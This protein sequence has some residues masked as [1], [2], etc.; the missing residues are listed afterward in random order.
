[1]TNTEFVKSQLQIVIDSSAQVARQNLSDWAR[2]F[3][4]E[5]P[6]D[7]F[8][9]WNAPMPIRSGWRYYVRAPHQLGTRES[10]GPGWYMDAGVR[11][12]PEEADATSA[13]QRQ[14]A[15]VLACAWIAGRTVCP[16]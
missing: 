7:L 3:D 6:L 15:V 10:Q 11:V 2:V 1:M 14:V 4:G 9:C 13:L 12:C 5:V 8:F 16:E